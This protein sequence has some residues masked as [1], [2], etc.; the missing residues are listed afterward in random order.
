MAKLLQEVSERY[1]DR[2]IILDSPPL[3]LAAETSA[4]SRVVSGILLV[5]KYDSTP[6]KLIAETI[7]NSG[8]DRIVGSILNNFS[9]KG[10]DYNKRYYSK[11]YK[12]N[13]D[14]V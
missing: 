2:F 10:S 12:N 5:I 1:N 13:F 4:L 7:E 8:K 3:R 14:E 11:Y 9:I 6:R